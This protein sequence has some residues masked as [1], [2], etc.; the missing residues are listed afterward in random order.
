M[1]NSFRRLL[2]KSQRQGARKIDERRRIFAVRCSEAIERNEAYEAFSAACW[3][4]HLLDSL[5]D[6]TYKVAI[7]CQRKANGIRPL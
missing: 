7:E 6:L 4:D 3:E 5:G 1:K 2:K